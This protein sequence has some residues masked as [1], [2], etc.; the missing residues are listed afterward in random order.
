MPFISPSRR[1]AVAFGL[2]LP[3]ALSLA[4]PS[5]AQTATRVRA[6]ISAVEGDRVT[7]RTKD[8]QELKVKLVEPLTVSARVRVDASAITKGV[9]IGAAAIPG[10]GGALAGVEI[11]VFPEA[12]RGTGEGHRPFDLLPESTMTNATVAEEVTGAD[13]R[14]VRV[15]YKGGE[16][17]IAIT[18]ETRVFTLQPG[19]TA[20]LKTGVAVNAAIEKD[21]S[22]EFQTKRL[23]VDR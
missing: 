10:T 8:G 12:M 19:S 17:T 3:F 5:Q 23:T 22:G 7:L 6:T 18:P 16:Q 14:S 1:K 11:L 4:T 15:T 21:A 2:A 9:F 13:G 20:D